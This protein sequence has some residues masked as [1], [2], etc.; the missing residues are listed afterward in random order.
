VWG[1]ALPVGLESAAAV[2]LVGQDGR[3]LLIAEL[4][5]PSEPSR[6]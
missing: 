2:H 1:G 6:E 3:S 5:N 4:G